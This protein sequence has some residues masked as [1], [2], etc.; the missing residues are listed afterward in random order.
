MDQEFFSPGSGGRP[1]SFAI[2]ASSESR[3]GVSF[4]GGLAG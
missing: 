3:S 2:S 1:S 4:L